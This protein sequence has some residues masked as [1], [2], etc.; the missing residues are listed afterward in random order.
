MASI[1]REF[2]VAASAEFA[3][4]AIREVGAVHERLAQGFVAETVLDGDVRTATFA[5]GFVVQERIVA[6][7]DE[8]KRLAYTA[9]NGRSSHHNAYFQVF[10]QGP[11]LARIAWVTD[12]LPEEVK[13]QIEQMVEQGIKSIQHTLA[14]AFEK[15]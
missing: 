14:A 1:Y 7:D 5:N 8:H 13:V 2:E 9:V 10:S 12:L 11:E 15:A 3:W 6:I 4:Q